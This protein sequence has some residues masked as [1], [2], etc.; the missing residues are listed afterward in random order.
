MLSFTHL[1]I[2][3]DKSIEILTPKYSKLN[4]FLDSLIVKC[5]NDKKLIILNNLK[6]QFNNWFNVIPVLSFN[7][8]KYDI[9][10]MKHYLHKALNICG[11]NVEFAIK[12]MSSY[13]SLRTEHLQFLDIRSYL[14][15]NYSYDAFIKAYK[16]I[17]TKG[18]FPYEYLDNFNKLNEKQLPPHEAFYSSL[19]NSNITTEQYCVL[20]LGIKIT[21]KT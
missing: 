7:G 5:T 13:M 16:C 4:E 9:N 11:E 10:L 21:C 19:K 18:F 20:M 3:I 17:L 1:E 12:K 2:P 15:P 14:A 6:K 8:S